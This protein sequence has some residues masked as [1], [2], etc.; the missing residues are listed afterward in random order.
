[1]T[2]LFGGFS[3]D[4]Y[5]GYEQTFPLKEGYIYRKN[6]YLLYHLLNHLNLFGTSYYRQCLQL[7]D[8][9]L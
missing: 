6:I 1:M 8:F 4:F 3:Q 2:Q 9:Y 7:M 5:Q